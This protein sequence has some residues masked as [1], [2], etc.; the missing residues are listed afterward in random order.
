[1]NNIRLLLTFAIASVPLFLNAGKHSVHTN[2]QK[3]IKRTKWT[4][5]EDM[6]LKNIAEADDLKHWR[7][8]STQFNTLSNIKRS[9]RSCRERY[10]EYLMLPL[11]RN[12]S[13]EED[14]K[15][16][17]LVNENGK[18]WTSIAALFTNKSAVILRNRYNLMLR[19]AKAINVSIDNLYKRQ[20]LNDKSN[21]TVAQQTLEAQQ[22][23]ELND[24]SF[25][26]DELFEHNYFDDEFNFNT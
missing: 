12:F 18:K 21:S 14:K 5:E 20:P 6:L 9:R 17:D 25:N 4:A 3:I 26:S 10:I 7:S 23:N 19:S 8:I 24:T 16:I 13:L 15:L 1:M 22:Y 11:D 2:E